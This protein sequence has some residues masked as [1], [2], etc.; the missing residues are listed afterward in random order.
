MSGNY[1]PGVTGNEREIAGG[2]AFTATVKCDA[3][4]MN[5]YPK[6]TVDTV[7]YEITQAVEHPK[8][9]RRSHNVDGWRLQN[10]HEQIVDLR[11]I[12]ARAKEAL[13]MDMFESQEPCTFEG[14]VDAE[15]Y[16]GIVEWECPL[17]GTEHSDD[18]Y[19]DQPDDP[20][21]KDD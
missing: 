19:F 9:V 7:L 1:P 13:D 15:V 18:A 14:E 11:A 16:D 4:A 5:V 2:D 6:M 8:T 12:L 3:P 21:R 10:A 20:D 17:C